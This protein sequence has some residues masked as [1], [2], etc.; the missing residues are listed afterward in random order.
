MVRQNRGITYLPY[1]AVQECVQEK[2]LVLLDVPDFNCKM[3][4]QI[5]YHK[6]KW[7]TPEMEEFIHLA[8][9]HV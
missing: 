2:K 5:F 8:K 4:L 3:Y 1:Y 6:N 9:S 7:A